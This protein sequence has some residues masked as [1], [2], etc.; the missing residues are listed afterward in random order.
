MTAPTRARQEI[1]PYKPL[2][3]EDTRRIIN[4][5]RRGRLNCGGEVTLSTSTTTTTV[6]DVLIT[7]NSRL[8]LSPQ[9]A[10]AAAA[11]TTTYFS[12]PTEGSIVIN[13]ANNA[14]TDRIFAYGVF[15]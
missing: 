3:D 8:F 9:T 4:D 7:T 1:P 14:Q 2:G 11:L 5:M 10:N 15:F 12:A 13:H 6:L